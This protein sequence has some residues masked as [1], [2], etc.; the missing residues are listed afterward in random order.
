[1]GITLFSKD[2]QKEY[3]RFLS[4]RNLLVHH[5]GV[6]T[7]KYEGQRFQSKQISVEGRRIHFDYLIVLKS[8]FFAWSEFL[9]DL[10]RK[11]ATTIRRAAV[12]KLV[13]KGITLDRERRSAMYGIAITFK[14]VGDAIERAVFDI[15][16]PRPKAGS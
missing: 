14:Q 15:F 10:A 9:T 8:D 7:L 2:D 1:L 16:S 3:G 6:F 11:M 12:R 13:E 5:G 4:D